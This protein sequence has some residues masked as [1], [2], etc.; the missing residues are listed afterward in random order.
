MPVASPKNALAALQCVATQGY[1]TLWA[2]NVQHRSGHMCIHNHRHSIFCILPPYMLRSIMLDGTGAQKA[3]ASATLGVD[4][5]FRAMRAQLAASVPLEVR[6][7]RVLGL[8]PSKQR[9]ISTAGNNETLPGTVVRSGGK[10]A[11]PATRRTMGLDGLGHTFDFFSKV[12]QRNSIDDEGL[13]LNATVHYGEAYPVNGFLERSANGFSETAT[14]TCSIG[15]PSHS[16]SSAM[17]SGTAL[18]KTR[19]G[20]STFQQPGALNEH[21]S[22]VRAGRQAMG[23]QAKR[24][25]GRVAYRGRPARFISTGQS[26]SVDEGSGNCLR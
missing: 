21:L 10:T 18:Q 17:S 15:S 25:Q 2:V 23:P 22:D 5:T 14:G 20:L 1:Q 19:L 3:A 24:G 6:R 12:Y 8:L 7:R 13:P 9:T 16:T 26:S 4:S 11:R